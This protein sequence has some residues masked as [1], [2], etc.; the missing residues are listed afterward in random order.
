MHISIKTQAL[1]ATFIVVALWVPSCF[2]AK[3]VEVH[4]I[5]NKALFLH[6][7]DSE[8][9]HRDDGIGPTAYTNEHEDDNDSII[10]FGQPLAVNA[11]TQGSNFTL[12]SADD[13][14]YGNAGKKAVSIG[15]KKKVNGTAELAWTEPWDFD[16][17]YTFSHFLYVDLPQPL[18]QG[19]SYTLSIANCNIDNSPYTFT[20]N[21]FSMRSE[22]IRSNLS[23]FF[24]DAPVKHVDVYLW[25]GDAGA[26]DFSLHEGKDVYL[27]NVATQKSQVVSTLS[28]WK[29]NGGD[30]RG[31]N[32]T[33]SDV[34]IADFTGTQAAGTYR[35]AIEDVGCSQEF[36]ISDNA[37]TVPFMV[38]TQGYFYMRIGQPATPGIDPKP[39]T[40]LFIPGESPANTTVWITEVQ[41]W[42]VNAGGDPWDKPD[43]WKPFKTNRTNPNAWGGHSDAYDWDRHLAHVSNIYDM[44]L[45]FVLTQ[46]RIDHDNLDIAESG[47][48]IPDILDEAR[49][50]VD[51]WLRL[52][53]G[54]GYSMGLTNPNGQN[55]LFQA[56]TRPTAAW[57]NALNCAML[58][59]CFRLSGHTALMQE[60]LDSALVAISVAA[61]QELNEVKDIG[62]TGLSGKDF[63]NNI[64]AY[65][66][67][68]TG[69]SQ[70]ENTY[71]QTTRINSSTAEF[72][73]SRTFNQ[74]YGAAAY[75]HSPHTVSKT[76][77]LQNI[78]ASIIHQAKQKEANFSLSRPSRRASADGNPAFWWP[79]QNV[80]RT[81]VA[82]SIAQGADK[83]LF[84]NALVL[85]ADWGLGR[86]S[87]NIIYM[88]TKTTPLADK[89]ATQDIYT[90]GRDDGSP[91]MHPG[92]TPYLNHDDWAC[93]MTMG[94]PSTLYN[95]TYPEFSKWPKSDGYFP[96]RYHWAHTEF[97]PRQTMRG[98][99]ALYGYLAGIGEKEPTSTKR[100]YSIG[101][102]K[103]VSLIKI[104][105]TSMTL[106]R[107]K[108]YSV[109]LFSLDGRV[110]WSKRIATDQIASA[111]LSQPFAPGVYLARLHNE[112][113]TVTTRLSLK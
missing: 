35:I 63:K 74:L 40:P 36:T 93:S 99:M 22:A 7:K 61:D 109:T 64:A 10:T 57:A 77:L 45:P 34:W 104:A 52:R 103:S 107:D 83:E 81:L 16:Y 84:F 19:S 87:D 113:H 53:D 108:K 21:F 29:S 44:L 2:S 98:K 86:N 70:W 60:Y 78:K 97:T 20:Y 3:I 90:T 112:A 31:Y 27:Y 65:M 88:T 58:A 18:K 111:L 54:Q 17:T 6:I 76:T 56:G 24:T 11:A 72:F 91:G 43:A 23:G 85:E 5:D 55:E 49:F 100:S 48:G 51:F 82:H 26:H 80:H 106:L 75:L 33:G 89:K 69:D 30:M 46:G 12:T 39:R 47:N 96:S 50:E 15:R 32:L 68:L 92:Q 79:A 13:P 66:F 38:S 25:K 67:N 41:R 105:G 102:N 42:D 59:E 73:D 8:I 71:A 14:T 37:Y 110:L 9:R 62:E 95:S 101:T 4:L 28:F 1:I 94:C